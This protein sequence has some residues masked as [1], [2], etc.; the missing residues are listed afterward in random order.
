MAKNTSNVAAKV[1]YYYQV[2]LILTGKN[3]SQH[4][5]YLNCPHPLRESRKYG[6]PL[7]LNDASRKKMAAVLSW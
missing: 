3:Y 6:D 5:N 7:F 4:L 1:R 2:F